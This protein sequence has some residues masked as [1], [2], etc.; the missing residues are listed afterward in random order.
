[1]TDSATK[2]LH[3]QQLAWAH[4]HNIRFNNKGYTET[5]DANLYRKISAAAYSAF[6]AGRGK[7][8]DPKKKYPKMQALHSSSALVVNVFDYWLQSNRVR[9]IAKA[10]GF[11]GI[12]ESMQYESKHS[13]PVK[14]S[15]PH[16]DIEFRSKGSNILALESKFDEPYGYKTERKIKDNYLR[17]DVWV[18]LNNCYKLVKEIHDNQGQQ[19]FW[20]YLDTPQ[21]LKHILGLTATY[22]R[23]KFTLL[24]LWY[25]IPSQES[26]DHRD[27]IANFEDRVKDDARFKTMTYQTLF[28]KIERIYGASQGYLGYMKTRYFPTP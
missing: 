23:R 16:L 17:P 7:E 27:Q 2:V 6:S 10:C 13:T 5:L 25:E 1:M 12:A 20:T 26:Q 19:T 8:I 22:G 11:T 9:D 18:G 28:K 4:H 14:N 21:L 24:Y 15:Y 3:D